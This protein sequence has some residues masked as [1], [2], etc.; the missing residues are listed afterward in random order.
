MKI[1]ELLNNV[2]LLNVLRSNPPASKFSGKPLT[3]THGS[4]DLSVRWENCMESDWWVGQQDGVYTKQDRRLVSDEELLAAAKAAGI[5]P[6]LVE[7]AFA[8]REMEE[9]AAAAKRDASR[10]I[11]Q[12][13]AAAQRQ[14]DQVKARETMLARRPELADTA[15]AA[16]AEAE[17]A[18]FFKAHRRIERMTR[19]LALYDSVG[20]KVGTFTN[21]PGMYAWL[22][23]H[24]F[25]PSIDN[26]HDFVKSAM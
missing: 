8:G 5:D 14:R 10:K 6:D 12:E 15:L 13:G 17:L 20:N 22:F 2:Q 23:Q 1:Q 16:A 21:L 26:R 11:W 25:S 24:G 9:A 18:E 4:D 7:M 19:K 3:L